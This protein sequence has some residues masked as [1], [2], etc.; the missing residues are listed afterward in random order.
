[1]SAIQQ[2][3][4]D[5]ASSKFLGTLA[6][7]VNQMDRFAVLKLVAEV[8]EMQRW[9]ALGGGD[10]GFD[11]LEWLARLPSETRVL[12]SGP[13]PGCLH[14]AHVLSGGH[15]GRPHTLI[16]GLDG[17]TGVSHGR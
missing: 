16:I 13:R 9:L 11:A 14:L 3:D 2:A 17:S 6:R 8:S 7:T 12:G 5:N 4:F 10:V 1:M 15:S